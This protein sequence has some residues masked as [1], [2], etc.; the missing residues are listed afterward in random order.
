MMKE[1][2]IKS[3]K[4][5]PSWFKLE[6]YNKAKYF[7]AYEWYDELMPRLFLRHCL[8]HYGK[9]PQDMPQ[10]WEL[11]QQNGLLFHV[12]KTEEIKYRIRAITPEFHQVKAL[13]EKPAQAKPDSL[14]IS[15]LLNFNM[16]GGSYWYAEEEEQQAIYKKFSALL[17]DDPQAVTDEL[18]IEARTWLN[19]SF[20]DCPMDQMMGLKS[21]Y[22]Y[23]KVDLEASDEQ[24]KKDLVIWLEQERKRR[25]KPAPKKNFSDADFSGW[26]E[27]AVLPYLD[28]MFWAEMEEVKI[29]QTAIAQA[30]FPDTYSLDAD[31]DPM[32]KLKTT[33][34]KAEYLMD[35]KTM[36]LLELQITD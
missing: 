25:D 36:K 26:H 3:A 10:N 29:N 15:S 2:L 21:K 20:L 7:N 30:I 11:I 6:N 28:L 8:K 23:A 31:V 5:L 27:S 9:K 22:A 32:G 16:Y 24:I 4:Q 35:H 1:N 19:Q 14:S 34:K 13:D 12:A 33:K 18:K 17:G